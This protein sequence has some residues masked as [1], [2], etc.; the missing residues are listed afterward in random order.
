[1]ALFVVRHQYAPERCAAQDPDMGC[2]L[3]NHLEHLLV[4]DSRRLAFASLK[5][6]FAEL[7][8]LGPVTIRPE[9]SSGE[10]YAR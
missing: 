6:F 7:T 4:G 8:V 9:S 2:M 5:D 3:L 1:M 10:N